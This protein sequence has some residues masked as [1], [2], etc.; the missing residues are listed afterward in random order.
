MNNK[1]QIIQKSTIMTWLTNQNYRK[2]VTISNTGSALSD[3]Q[4]L[5]TI[6][7]ATLITAGKMRP[8][9]RDIRLTDVDGSTL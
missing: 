2:A 6:D 7:T 9:C 3:Y 8:D 5:I 4:V 1:D